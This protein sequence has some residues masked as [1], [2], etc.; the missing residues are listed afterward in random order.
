M[1]KKSITYTN[2][3][4]EE[5]TKE[6]YFHL[7]Q[8]KLTQVEVEFPGGFANA[9]RK[10]SEEQDLKVLYHIF[11]TL[12][13]TSYGVKS[14]DGEL[15]IQNEKLS[16]EFSYSPAYS[17][18]FSELLENQENAEAFLKAIIPAIKETK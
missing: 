15:F 14:E 12:I 13:L 17:Q 5:K 1:I 6:C 2:F 18:L 7:S 9:I 16:E 3:N 11:K 10:A 8:E 4:G